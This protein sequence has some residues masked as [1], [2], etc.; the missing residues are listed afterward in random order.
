M[1]TTV[2]R[3]DTRKAR[4]SAAEESFRKYAE[5]YGASP[6]QHL[7]LNCPNR[8]RRRTRDLTIC[9]ITRETRALSVDTN[10]NSTRCFFYFIFVVL[11]IYF[12]L[13]A[14]GLFLYQNHWLIG[15]LKIL[16]AN[17]NLLY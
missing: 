10:C 14:A 15:T 8:Y 12:S 17:A 1:K 2:V 7:T 3:H 13:E 11:L 5:G 16:R 4:E 6:T 9:F